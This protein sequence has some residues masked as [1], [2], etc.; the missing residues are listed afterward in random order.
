MSS[1]R[2]LRRALALLVAVSLCLLPYPAQAAGTVTVVEQTG[3]HIRKIAWSWTCTA[4]GAADLVTTNT[5]TGRIV[6]L[7]TDPG[8]TAPTDDYDITVTDQ[9]GVDV[10]NALGANRD[11]ANT[12][13]V[14]TG[15]GFV[16]GST[17]TLN[18]TNAGSAKVGQ[19]WLYVQ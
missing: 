1:V 4:G 18:V 15:M 17:L 8:A 9:D 13:Q 14:V 5:Y 11:T 16:V 10:L 2:N 3:Y 12:E 7:V 6:G 19:V